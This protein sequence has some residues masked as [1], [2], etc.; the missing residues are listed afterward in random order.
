[1]MLFPQFKTLSIKL[2][3]GTTARVAGLVLAVLVLALSAS[4]LNAVE[5]TALPINDTSVPISPLNTGVNT[6]QKTGSLIIGP[7]GGTSKLCLNAADSTD[8]SGN[9]ISDW[10][11]IATTRYVALNQVSLP[12]FDQSDNGY[13]TLP[14]N[15]AQQSGYSDLIALNPTQ[16]V[17]AAINASDVNICIRDYASQDPGYCFI[18]SNTICYANSDCASPTGEVFKGTA[19]YGVGSSNASSYAGYFGGTVYVRAPS[20]SLF[21]SNDLGRI[22]LG[23]FEAPY[24]QVAGGADGCISSWNELSSSVAGYVKRQTANPPVSQVF[25]AAISGSS[26]FGSAVLGSTTGIPLQYTC[27]NGICDAS[28]SAN[29]GLPQYCA[30]D[31]V[32]ISPPTNFNPKPSTSATLSNL[33][34]DLPITAAAQQPTSVKILIVR[35]TGAAPTFSPSNGV[36]YPVGTDLGNNTVVV[37]NTTATAGQAL[38]NLFDTL[39]IRGTYYY[40]AFQANLYPQYSVPTAA[41]VMT[42]RQLTASVNPVGTGTITS[43]PAGL[44]CSNNLPANCT[45]LFNDGITVAVTLGNV[46]TGYTI[47][48][49][50]GCTTSN[51]YNCTV[52]M[53]ADKVIQ[54]NLDQSGDPGGGGGGIIDFP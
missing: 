53:S 44:S 9:C 11:Q 33:K 39:P 16:H 17:T 18:Q 51:G 4:P 14:A 20:T 48:N 5:R 54:A 26:A 8:T 23:S 36:D 13:A 25:G 50:T 52:V 30:I 3:P 6:Q 34:I 37:V 32:T 19:V 2:L 1:M 22:C 10:S 38:T 29:P 24:N 42:P 41:M 47:N 45:K 31:C 28:E 12:N 21:S 15:Y 35:R 27:G 40:Q 46:D 7:N 43:S 49:W